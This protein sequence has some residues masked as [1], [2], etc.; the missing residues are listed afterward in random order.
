MTR[1]RIHDWLGAPSADCPGLTNG[2]VLRWR[3]AG[4]FVRAYSGRANEQDIHAYVA[5][6]VL[7]GIDLIDAFK[8]PLLKENVRGLFDRID[9]LTRLQWAVLQLRPDLAAAFSSDGEIDRGRF[10]QWTEERF[11]DEFPRVAA[12]LDEQVACGPAGLSNGNWL[13]WNLSPSLR[14]RFDLETQDG[15]LSYACWLLLQDGR[16]IAGVRPTFTAEQLSWCG[17]LLGGLTRLQW[18]LLEERADLKAAFTA[19][20]GLDLQGF[21][22]WFESRFASEYQHVYS[23]LDSAPRIGQQGLGAAAFLRWS[24]SP[25]LRERFDIGTPAGCHS[26]IC[27][28]LLEDP[29]SLAPDSLLDKPTAQWLLETVDG[30]TGLQRSLLD[31]REDLRRTF[32]VANAL[33]L[34][35]YRNWFED[36]FLPEHPELPRWIQQVLQP[37]RASDSQEDGGAPLRYYDQLTHFRPAAG[38]RVINL[39]GYHRAHLGIGEDMRML[40][41]ALERS[42]Y[43]INVL[44][45]SDG[46]LSEKAERGHSPGVADVAILDAISIF[47]CTAPEFERL[48]LRFGLEFYERNY[49]IGYFPWELTKWHASWGAAE[50]LVDR[51]WASTSFIVGAF[52]PWIHKPVVRIPLVVEY[53]RLPPANREMFGLGASSFVC[54]FIFDSLSYMARKNPLAHVR[55]F[56]QAFRGDE[57][58]CLVIKTM[59]RDKTDALLW[60]SLMAEIEGDERIRVI[61]E[62]MAKET[63]LSLY[64][65]A[66]AYLS[67][68]RAEG[69]G[70]T[71]AEAM[72]YAKPVIVSAYSGNMDYCDQ[73]NACLVPGRLVPVREG[74]YPWFEDTEWFDPDISAAARCLRELYEDPVLRG[75]KGAA[76]K[77]TMLRYTS[78]AVYEKYIEQELGAIAVERREPLYA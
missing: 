3:Y 42:D 50:E 19:D 49:C 46:L 34:V 67:L 47:C 68:H 7:Q 8:P 72:L 44:D 76:G 60:R 20:T 43:R 29:S 32:H 6:L 35:E 51:I 69:F 24:Q 53:D 15:R 74:E 30:L 31:Y 64:A 4:T 71:I 2:A 36:H 1:K 40:Q 61:N 65:S 12:Y 17:Q 37:V 57:D 52:Q 26:L 27:W 75:K 10:E 5:W 58:V 9:G 14:A 22:E 54:L 41:R 38:E 23:K 48:L 77:S 16:R 39:I 11:L 28:L 70:R 62:T 33:D 13:R 18:M 63:L 55:A 21:L 66:D 25:G 59:N 45:I 73:E 78:T 56:K